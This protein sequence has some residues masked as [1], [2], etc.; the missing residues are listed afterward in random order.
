[1]SN[2]PI[3]LAGTGSNTLTR[4]NLA[5]ILVQAGNALRKGNRKQAALLFGAATIAPRYGA[6]SHLLQGGITLNNLRK[7]LT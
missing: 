1:M 6:A 3:D 2:E 5:S 4:L 7:R